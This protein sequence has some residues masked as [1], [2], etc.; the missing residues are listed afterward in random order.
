MSHNHRLSF[1]LI[2]LVDGHLSTGIPCFNELLLYCTKKFFV[3]SQIGGSW[4]PCI[5]E[6]YQHHF[7]KSICFLCV[8]HILV[9]HIST[10]FS[11]SIFVTMIWDQWFMLLLAIFG[12]FLN[13]YVLLFFR[14]NAIAHLIDCS[15]E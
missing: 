11:N 4:W 7:S 5:E 14:H 10:F 9:I 3:F 8:S 13:C 1:T 2:S 6:V 12:V 15:M